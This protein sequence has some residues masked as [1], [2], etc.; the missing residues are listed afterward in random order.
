MEMIFQE[1]V[2]KRIHKRFEMLEIFV[3]E[4]FIIPRLAKNI[5]AAVPAIVNMIIHSLFKRRVARVWF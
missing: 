2:T 3:D 1:G 5:L 4:I